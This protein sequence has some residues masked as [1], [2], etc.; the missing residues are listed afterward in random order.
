M[1]SAGIA[2]TASFLVFSY[3]SLLIILRR[4]YAFGECL[5]RSCRSGR[6]CGRLG[7]SGRGFRAGSGC[8]GIRSGC[9]GCGGAGTDCDGLLRCLVV[10]R[11]EADRLGELAVDIDVLLQVGGAGVMVAALDVPVAGRLCGVFHFLGRGSGA[12]D[13]DGFILD[14][15]VG[16]AVFFAVDTEGQGRAVRRGGDVDRV[17]GI[18]CEYEILGAGCDCSVEGRLY[19]GDQHGVRV[20]GIDLKLSLQQSIVQRS[21]DLADAAAIGLDGFTVQV[22]AADGVAVFRLAGL[23][24]LADGEALTGQENRAVQVS[25]SYGDVSLAAGCAAAVAG[26][27]G[28]EAGINGLQHLRRAGGLRDFYS[29]LGAVENGQ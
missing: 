16:R 29:G 20:T 7:R 12:A 21:A 10:I 23:D 9:G 17:A 6:F 22:L 8:R 1:L 19:V 14:R 2:D 27:V 4:I 24:G 5:F 11:I 3:N 13:N 15:P 18:V 25:S 26:G 28:A